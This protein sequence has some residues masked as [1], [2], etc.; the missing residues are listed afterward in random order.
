MKRALPVNKVTHNYTCSL[1]DQLPDDVVTLILVSLYGW[2]PLLST[3]SKK[4]CQLIEQHQGW[5]TLARQ[6]YDRHQVVCTEHLIRYQ[7]SRPVLSLFREVSPEMAVYPYGSLDYDPSVIDDD[8]VVA[9]IPGY[10]VWPRRCHKPWHDRN[11]LLESVKMALRYLGDYCKDSESA[12]FKNF[13]GKLLVAK[14]P[15]YKLWHTPL[16]N[17]NGIY[18]D[19]DVQCRMLQ[20]L[21]YYVETE[22]ASPLVRRN[23]H[24]RDVN[25]RFTEVGHQYT[26]YLWDPVQKCHRP[27][28]SYRDIDDNEVIGEL[29]YESEPIDGEEPGGSSMWRY[30][31]E[32]RRDL[33]SMTTFIGTLYAPFNADEAIAGMK[34]N[35]KK[36]AS[37]QQNKYFGMSDDE[38]KK[39]W[40]DKRDKA[41]AA[42][43]A[44]HLNLERRYLGRAH[45]KG[46]KELS[47]YEEFER[48]HVTG[49]LRPY[50]TEWM[51]WDQELMWCG[52]ID[53][54]FEYVP[55]HP[56]HLPDKDGKKHLIVGDYKRCEHVDEFNSFQSGLP[57][58]LAHHAGNCSYIRYTIQTYGGYK[59]KLEKH[60]D[61]V[62]DEVWLIV[63]H[64]D[65][66]T[67]IKID[68]CPPKYKRQCDAM[69][70]SIRA[71]RLKRLQDYRD[72]FYQHHSVGAAFNI[73]EGDNK[74]S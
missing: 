67:Y 46:T 42:G 21:L 7:H 50:R 65:Q 61:V 41:S 1:F 9:S 45:D 20:A 59:Y 11:L 30:Y 39:Q 58:T 32:E 36:W 51:V 74:T 26:L 28:K 43:T 72:R 44:M 23:F 22:A 14:Y 69:M 52:S 53:I 57:G 62:V 54:V 37:P 6:L 47:H 13:V 55:G 63:L 60:Y 5:F 70:D 29:S 33:S 24:P 25:I 8:T 35:E 27:L 68:V 10:V 34:A 17:L 56:L 71:F 73:D 18:E 38:I 16:M 12:R 2:V 66:K 15:H 40:D 3:V 4:W 64:P 19:T 49:K 48:R 31:W